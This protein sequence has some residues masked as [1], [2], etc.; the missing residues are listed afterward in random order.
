[1]IVIH[2][3]AQIA[4]S[5][6]RNV[7]QK[8]VKN[9]YENVMIAMKLPAEI[10][11]IVMALLFVS[12]TQKSVLNV[13]IVVIITHIIMESNTTEVVFQIK[14]TVLIMFCFALASCSH[15]NQHKSK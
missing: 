12:V 8:N 13:I 3:I 10:G 4:K 14:T 2:I 6:V 11:A 5:N 15:H 9:V 7:T 1:V